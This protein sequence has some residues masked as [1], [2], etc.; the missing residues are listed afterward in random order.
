MPLTQAQILAMQSGV[1]QAVAN[2]PKN[3]GST[4]VNDPIVTVGNTSVPSSWVSPNPNP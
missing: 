2:N 4:V 3:L 1:A